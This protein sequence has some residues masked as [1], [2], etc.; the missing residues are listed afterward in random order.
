VRYETPIHR[1]ARFGADRVVAFLIDQGLSPRAKTSYGLTILAA[2]RQSRY[3]GNVLPML[4]ERLK[5]SKSERGEPPKKLKELSEERMLG[6]LATHDLSGLRGGADTL[7]N[8]ADSIFVEDY[9]VTIQE[10]Y[11]MIQ[12]QAQFAPEV[13]FACIDLVK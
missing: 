10:F 13:L 1:A 6:Y 4:I 9:S 7:R 11:E 12:E 8:I 5:A 2:A 3:S